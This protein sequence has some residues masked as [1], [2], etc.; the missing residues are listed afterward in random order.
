MGTSTLIDMTNDE[1]AS[2]SLN[3]IVFVLLISYLFKVELHDRGYKKKK[4]SVC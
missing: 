3:E 2:L 4:N 1:E